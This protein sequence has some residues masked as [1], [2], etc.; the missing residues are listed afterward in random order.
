MLADK[1]D[2]ELHK[3]ALLMKEQEALTQDKNVQLELRK[4]EDIAKRIDDKVETL[5]L[6]P[7]KYFFP[8]IPNS[9]VNGS[10]VNPIL[11][12]VFCKSCQI[13]HHPHHHCT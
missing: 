9:Y 13:H 10:P 2:L 8:T 5:Q 1:E 3:E 11:P 6:P 12:H 4:V 7:P